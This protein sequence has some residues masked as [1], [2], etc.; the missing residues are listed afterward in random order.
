MPSGIYIRTKPVWNKGIKMSKE[1]KEK[2]KK[3]LT[4]KRRTKE[5][6]IEIS[7]R[8]KNE[9]KTGKRKP[10]LSMLGRRHTEESKEKCRQ[11]HLKRKEIL[12]YVNSPQTRLKQKLAIRPIGDKS[13]NWKGGKSFELYGNE[14]TKELKHSIRIRDKFVCQ[15]CNKHG[16]MVH[17]IDYNKLNNNKE[18]LVTLCNKCHSKTNGNRTYWFNFFTNMFMTKTINTWQ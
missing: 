4:G 14:W 16:W 11:S 6:K 5:Q 2:L 8:I 12:G 9:Y 18:N 13:A 10:P 3:S 17:H 15:N 7:S 1:A